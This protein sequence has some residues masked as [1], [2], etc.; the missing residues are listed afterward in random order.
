MNITR[1]LLLLP[2]ILVAVICHAQVDNPFES[3]GKKGKIITLSNG[4][5]VETFDYDS[6]ER[7]GTVLINIRTRKVVR[8]LNWESTF[9]KFSDN[10]SSSRWWSP[11]PLAYKYFDLSPYNYVDNNPISHIDPDGREI[12]GETKNDAKKALK[13]VQ[14]IF[15]GDRFG[16]F[17]ALLG[18]KGSKFQ[19]IDSKALAGVLSSDKLSKDDKALITMVANTINSA[20]KHMVEYVASGGNLSTDASNALNKAAKGALQPVLDANGG[21]MSAAI[22]SAF[23]GSGITTKTDDGTFS[24]LITGLDPSKGGTDYYNSDTKTMGSSPAGEPGTVGHEVFGHG[25]SLALGRTGSQQADAIQTENLILRVMGFGNT[26]R[27]GTDHG[28]RTK[29]DN[30]SALPG[31]Q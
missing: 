19:S 15:K 20:D 27:D 12:I 28:D 22:A 23:G 8:L 31:Y 7:I 1:T 13:D 14:A 10:S 11:D 25:R 2:L 17:N 21:Q 26:Q 4:K 16:A 5:Y 3:I 6:I 24:V 29:V 18:L 30:P 9:Q